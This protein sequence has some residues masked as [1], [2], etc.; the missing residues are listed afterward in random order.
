MPR[1][2]QSKV[3]SQY[4]ADSLI[5]EGYKTEVS[6]LFSSLP[7]TADFSDHLIR[8]F[9]RKVDR[10]GLS[11]DLMIAPYDAGF[12]FIGTLIQSNE[13]NG[14]NGGNL[15]PQYVISGFA[16]PNETLVA[17][18][19]TYYDWSIEGTTVST[20][21]TYVP[22][23]YDIGKTIFC[24]VNGISYSID[25]W[26][27]NQI[28]NLKTFWWAGSPNSVFKSGT[29]NTAVD[30]EYVGRF[31]D[32]VSGA[33]AIA[34][35]SQSTYQTN[36]LN[37]PCIQMAD[38]SFF[39]VAEPPENIPLNQKYFEVILGAR[40]TGA[41]NNS[42]YLFSTSSGAAAEENI[43]S[44]GPLLNSNR[45][46]FITSSTAT[47]AN[48]TYTGQVSSTGY[49]VYAAQAA[50]AS[51][52]MNLRVNGAYVASGSMQ[53][54]GVSAAY[55]NVMYFNREVQTPSTNYS[56]PC[57]LTAVAMIAG[58]NPLSNTDRIRLE[59]FIGLLHDV[60]IPLN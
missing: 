47:E 30:D 40:A 14:N 12:R 41:A 31:T 29:A 10:L 37:T 7:I 38:G 57:D 43:L 35:G 45:T 52:F 11:S 44:F 39:D 34:Y 24:I 60:N 50:Y 53:N 51:G 6:G 56:N 21:S 58:D 3:H 36:V 9:N 17:P 42:H 46:Y 18:Q 1:S 5:W 8:E 15:P 54:T 19:G 26:H 13:Q 33:D 23:V 16:F 32:I 59:R 4:S 28:S 20:G 48:Y 55:N 27:P 49:A 2:L 25:M 22:T